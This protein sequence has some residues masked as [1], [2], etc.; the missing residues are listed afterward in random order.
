[1][2]KVIFIFLLMATSL[3]FS[4]VTK[5][6][7]SGFVRSSEG[8][9]LPGSSVEVIHQPTG[10]KYYANADFDGSYSVPSI[11]PG[12]PYVVK[13][14]FVGYKPTVIDEINAPLGGNVTVNL[15][16]NS[17]TSTLKEVVIKTKPSSGSL[18]SKGRTGASQQ[19]ST[20]E[21][22][23]IPVTGARSITAI[24]KYNANAGSGGSFGGQ[25]SRL[26]NFTIDGSAFNNGFG[27]GGEAQAGGR[28]GSSAISLDAIE[29]LQINIAP[30][31]VRQ[32][33][34][35]GSGINAVTRSGTNQFEGSIYGAI[36]NNKKEF[37]GTKAGRIEIVPAKFDEQTIGIRF[38]APIIKNKLFFFGNFEKIENISPATTWTASDSP[39]RGA[40]VSLPTVADLDLVS[41]TL[42]KFGYITGPYENYDAAKKSTKFL[43]RL[44]WNINDNNKLTLRY[45]QHDSFSE[46]LTSNSNSL[47]FGNRRTNQFSLAYKNS[48]YLIK[49]NTRSI[50]AELDTKISEKWSNNLLVGYDYQNEDRDLLGG[51]LF[52]T[53]DIK[54]GTNNYISAGL[55]PF[56]QGNRLDYS[57]LH[58]TDNV[59][60]NTGK[61]KLLF[62]INLERFISNNSFFPG[63]NGVYIFDSLSDF[64]NAANGSFLAGGAPFASNLPSRF[65]F[66]YS[67]LPGKAEP[68]QTLKSNRVDLYGQ[69]DIKV[70]DRF[71]LVLGLRA[72]AVA[73]ENTTIDNP[74]VA[75][76]TFANGQKLSTGSMPDT[77][78]LF[79][80]RIGFNLDVYGDSSTQVRGGSG[81][82]S[83]KAPAVLLSNAIGNNGVLTGFIDVSGDALLAGGQGPSG[84]P[85]G[86]YGFTPR[87]EQY[88]TPAN[89]GT[90][91]SYD[92]A[93]TAKNFKFP[94][95]WK[96]TVAV[97]QKLPYGFVGTIEGI[98][99]K[100]INE[101]Y[102]YN[103]NLAAPVGTLNGS[104]SGDS[105]PYY[106]GTDN[107]SRINNNVSNAIVLDNTSK[108][109]FYST[110]I[111]LEYPY[112]KGLWG[113]LAY[114]RSDAYDIISAGSIAAGSW[115]GARSV[116]GNN[117]LPLSISSNNTPNRI[118]GLIGYR[119][120]YG[121]GNYSASTS[122]NIGYIGEQT[123]A[124][125]YTYGGDYNGD[126]VAGNDLIFVP[127]KA[128]DLRFVPIT[129]T[130]GSTLTLFSVAEQ[131]AAF[132]KFIDQDPYLSSRRG[133]YA[134][135]N[136]NVLP[137]LHKLDLSVTQDF[138]IKI[139]GK[140]NTFQFRA[141]ILNFTNL[142]NRSWG[143]SQRPTASN[144]LIT[145]QVANSGN[146]FIPGVQLAQQVDEQGKVSLIKDTF[147][148][149]ASVFDVW[150]AQFTLR[151]IFGK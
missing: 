78:F 140:K 14:T 92:L 96:T 86:P 11:R 88:Y 101:S 5:S 52:P 134:Q 48:G 74:V 76:Y 32:S 44:D 128:S 116:N 23:A 141:D 65:Q 129:Q 147:I 98:F 39:L 40:Q 99:S 107:G 24:T 67:A 105:R 38:G 130:V 49:D 57:T 75:G 42:A 145:N 27:L 136:S 19:F 8:S 150:Q 82:F 132:D 16:L 119:F 118:V 2:K 79:E 84:A 91:S 97:D 37:V 123:G 31:D 64:T 60:K 53:I 143:V 46:E 146:G 120:D 112:K 114:T 135:R 72:S 51:G 71:R 85:T 62:G 124:F 1:M 87:P 17:E 137:M 149:N 20:R 103:A 36:R 89:A 54:N 22:T 73:F 25:D 35:T 90:P 56:T 10:T 55:D 6:A 104:I 9:P 13:A 83:G 30:F 133:Q 77:Q 4:Q 100:N 138:S 121:K 115:T 80:P 21:L 26:N 7:I 47:G 94:Q 131:E 66:R 28:T 61:N 111:K 12:G 70:S 151:Y 126:R 148:K 113:S 102:Y 144:I 125:S 58:I 18:F 45:I 106:S 108:G 109:Y 34:F 139:A 50:V 127:N 69:D 93:F 33:G 117:N 15:L 29:Q 142:L 3:G 81:I 59:S 63:S 95:A 41:N 110:T 68:L 122:I 43:T